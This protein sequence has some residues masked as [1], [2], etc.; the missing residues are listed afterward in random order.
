MGSDGVFDNLFLDEVVDL[1]NAMLP[2]QPAQ[3]QFRP[4]PPNLFSQLARRIVDESHKKSQR[5]VPKNMLPETPIGRGGKMDDTSCVVGEVVEWTEAHSEAW[6]QVRRQRQWQ[7]VV[8]CG[9]LASQCNPVKNSCR[10]CNI[11]S[12]DDEIDEFEFHNDQDDRYHRGL[13][14]PAGAGYPQ[15]GHQ[16]FH[17]E[18]DDELACPVL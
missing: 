12:D 3:G 10:N 1:A 4:S 7:N 6:A 16:R 8:T 2:P 11:G 17:E 5:G 18:S 9:G 14:K 13:A 15:G